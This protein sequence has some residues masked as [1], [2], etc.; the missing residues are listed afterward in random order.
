MHK[1]FDDPKRWTKYWDDPK[2]D[3]WQKPDEVIAALQLRGDETVA[4]IGAGT[5][6][7]SV[8]LAKQLPQGNVIAVELAQP[9]VDWINDRAKKAGIDN[10]T[11]IQGAP[12][13]PKLPT[14]VDVV[15]LVNVYH[16]IA[17]RAAYFTK[18]KQALKPK[19]KLAI[20]DFRMG[21]MPF[22]PKD[23]HKISQHQVKREL[24][25]IGLS[26]CGS[27][28]GLPYQYMR[29]FCADTTTAGA[30]PPPPAGGTEESPGS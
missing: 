22:G 12:D 28:D 7:F 6:Y 20:V 14:E 17:G 26:P 3:Q 29:L 21:D 9:M 8:R 16:H 13:D 24:E 2:R 10:V 23:P 1:R 30:T 18:V 19:G 27:Y 25:S 4:D 5:G 11:A 15:L